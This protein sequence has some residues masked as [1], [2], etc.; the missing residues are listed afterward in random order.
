[1][2][3]QNLPAW[4]NARGT[5]G[6][7][8]RIAQTWKVLASVT[9]SVNAAHDEPL[10]VAELSGSQRDAQPTFSDTFRRVHGHGAQF[11]APRM[12]ARE[13]SRIGPLR[14]PPT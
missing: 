5:L 8:D 9:R 12:R 7:I 1:V 10:I 4:G 2:T 14:H 6:Q 3:P 11:K 13:G